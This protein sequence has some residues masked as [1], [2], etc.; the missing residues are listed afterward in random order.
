[1][2]DHG[3]WRWRWGLATRIQWMLDA[4]CSCSDCVKFRVNNQI[5]YAF[6]CSHEWLFGM[7]GPILISVPIVHVQYSRYFPSFLSIFSSFHIFSL[8]V[9]SLRHCAIRARVCVCEYLPLISI[10]NN[11]RLTKP[12]IYTHLSYFI[13][14][15]NAISENWILFK[16]KRGRRRHFPIYH[17]DMI[18]YILRSGELYTNA[19]HYSFYYELY[20]GWC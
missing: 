10:E 17:A 16:K 1:M 18:I 8:R 20:H 19:Y 9:F 5:K 15:M 11:K 7:D 13:V 6:G 12:S 14:I 2:D 3:R 4:Y